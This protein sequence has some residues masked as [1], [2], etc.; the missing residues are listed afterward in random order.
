VEV[1]ERTMTNLGDSSA[2]AISW[3]NKKVHQ[4]IERLAI[5]MPTRFKHTIREKIYV[6]RKS[7]RHL[8]GRIFGI[9]EATDRRTGGW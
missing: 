5:L 4:T 9:R 6:G 8:D 1:L 7:Y 2:L 3:R